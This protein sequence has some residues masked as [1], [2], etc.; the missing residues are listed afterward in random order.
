MQLLWKKIA[1]SLWYC[2]LLDTSTTMYSSWRVGWDGQSLPSHCPSS[3]GF[4]LNSSRLFQSQQE[5]LP[6][7]L[8]TWEQLSSSHF[9]LFPELWVSVSQTAPG[10]P[11]SQPQL[12]LA[13]SATLCLCIVGPGPGTWWL[14]SPRPLCIRLPMGPSVQSGWSSNWRKYSFLPRPSLI[15][16]NC[17]A[18]RRLF[19][20]FWEE[21]GFSLSLMNWMDE[22][23]LTW[24]W[25]FFHLAGQP[26]LMT[27]SVSQCSLS[28]HQYVHQCACPST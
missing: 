21:G 15:S 7:P 9:L 22:S 19:L 26:V 3:P 8:P 12:E 6:L 25:Y 16:H 1:N 2:C 27:P 4:Q 24:V 5:D 17:A 20:V 13:S 23:G 11:C 28:P 10:N 18:C 14:S